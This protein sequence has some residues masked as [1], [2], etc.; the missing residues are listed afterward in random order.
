MHKTRKH[1]F[2]RQKRPGVLYYLKGCRDGWE[3]REQVLN[4]FIK[5]FCLV[6]NQ[7]RNSESMDWSWE[8]SH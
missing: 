5:L 7:V 1:Q 8:I 2:E 3:V 4:I 6:V